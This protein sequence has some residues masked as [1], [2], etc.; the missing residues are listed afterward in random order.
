MIYIRYYRGKYKKPRVMVIELVKA[1]LDVKKFGFDKSIIVKDNFIEENNYEDARK[2][3]DKLLKLT[4]LI[5]VQGRDEEFNRKVLENKKVKIL[6]DS[7]NTNKEA[8]LLQRN[9]GLNHVLCKI[10][11]ENNIIIGINLQE[12][13]KREGKE[14]ADY[15]AKVMQ[16]VMLCKKYK[17]KMLM[18]TFANSEN[19][20]RNSYDM[21]AL[22][23]VLGMDTKMAKEA[24]EK[25]FLLS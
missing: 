3:I 20:L 18:T 21:K 8:N 13:V 4:N 24:V 6:L 19:E 5:I 23:L 22:C 17:S 25:G 1:E 7:E 9:S 15:L 11:K 14:R 2:K 12:I 16:N 10:A